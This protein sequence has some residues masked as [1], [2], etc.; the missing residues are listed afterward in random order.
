MVNAL[1]KI[2]LYV[3]GRMELVMIIVPVEELSLEEKEEEYMMVYENIKYYKK[4]M[5]LI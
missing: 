1:V 4:S 5:I 2:V 3:D